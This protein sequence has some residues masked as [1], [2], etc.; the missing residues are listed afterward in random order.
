MLRLS[1]SQSQSLRVIQTQRQTQVCS[2]SLTQKL[3]L[4]HILALRQE[5]LPPSFPNP[6]KGF[7]GMLAARKYLIE[8][9]AVG[10]LVGGLADAIWDPERT[11][12][13]LFKHKDVDVLILSASQPFEKF[14]ERIDWW[15]PRE[16]LFETVHGTSSVIHNMTCRYWVN[17]CEVALCYRVRSETLLRPGLY[18]PSPDC[19]LA[20]RVQE[21]YA[22]IDDARVTVEG[23]ERLFVTELRKELG[24]KT[25]L[26]PF[27]I[28]EFGRATLP[29]Y[30]SPEGHRRFAF[31]VSAVPL[32]EQKALNAKGEQTIG[33]RK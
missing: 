23:D 20:I 32:D 27:L 22:L 8:Q 26:P 2:L 6:I 28:S 21:A 9:G 33:T 29:Y 24:I 15:E 4:K 16:Y 1:C 18:F 14:A 30:E 17:G 5:L 3:L 11:E 31:S 10:L 13:E 12:D 7:P 19:A 25:E